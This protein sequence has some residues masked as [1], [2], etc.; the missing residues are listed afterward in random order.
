VASSLKGIGLPDEPVLSSG[1][2]R[3]DTLVT[4]LERFLT[5]VPKMKSVNV[6]LPTKQPV[7]LPL[8]HL[9][10]LALRVYTVGADSRVNRFDLHLILAPRWRTK[11][12]CS[13]CSV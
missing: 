2:E 1:I 3:L 4:I 6:S 7:N 12:E 9:V 5:F 13:S 11:A 8:G 10:D